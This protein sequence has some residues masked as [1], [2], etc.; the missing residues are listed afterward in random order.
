MDVS[1]HELRRAIAGE[2][3]MSPELDDVSAC[4]GGGTIPALWRRVVPATEKSLADWLQQLLHRNDQYKS[5][6]L[7]GLHIQLH[8]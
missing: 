3:G 6:V 2:V 5:W 4:L 7:L 8:F 1:L